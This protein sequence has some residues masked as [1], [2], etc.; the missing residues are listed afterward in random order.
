M[1]KLD[2]ELDLPPV[3]KWFPRA[4]IDPTKPNPIPDE[5]NPRTGGVTITT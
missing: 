5:S 2:F 3:E 1:I 4:C